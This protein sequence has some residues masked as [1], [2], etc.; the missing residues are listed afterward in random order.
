[1]ALRRIRDAA[2]VSEIWSVR[3]VAFATR[4]PVLALLHGP[5]KLPVDVTLNSSTRAERHALLPFLVDKRVQR[6]IGVV[7]LWAHRREIYGK[8][9]GRL[10]G[11][12]FAQLAIF[13]VQVWPAHQ[14]LSQMVCGFFAFYAERFDWAQECVSVAKG[15][16]VLKASARLRGI[17]H[18]SVEDCTDRGIDLC[19]PHLSEAENDRLY[20]EFRRASDILR[21]G[22]PRT[23]GTLQMVLAELEQRQG[24]D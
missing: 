10:S 21:G 20:L 18:L 2:Q 11:F 17:P 23:G 6:L 1:M 19:I 16:R 7:K 13:Y 3:N 8:A 24:A 4:A 9:R 14:S 5:T 12:A 15:R 22:P